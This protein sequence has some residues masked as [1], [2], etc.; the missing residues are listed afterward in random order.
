LYLAG[1]DIDAPPRRCDARIKAAASSN[2]VLAGLPAIGTLSVTNP[3]PGEAW[4][5]SR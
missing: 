2:A 5:I 4:K 1:L 3:Q